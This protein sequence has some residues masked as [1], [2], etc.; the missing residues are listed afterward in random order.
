MNLYEALY[1]R[2]TNYSG[3]TDLVS[4]RIY[5]IKMPQ[6]VTYPAVTFQVI[7]GLPR[8]HLMGSDDSLAAPRVQVSAWGESLSDA[9]DVADQ[10][11]AALQDF[12]GTMGGDGGVTVQRIFLESDQISLYDSESEIYHVAQDFF[13]WWEEP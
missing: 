11:R 13:I 9:C 8:T 5:P 10:I 12:S 3:L 7:S 2:L 1:H 6:A 4:T